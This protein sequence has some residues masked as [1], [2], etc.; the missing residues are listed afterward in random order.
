MTHNHR[1]Q[2]LHQEGQVSQQKA[3][4]SKSVRD[5]RLTDIIETG[6]FPTG[7]KRFSNMVALP[8]KLL[9]GGARLKFG[10]FR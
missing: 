6:N 7:A 9:L 3:N 8:E 2:G 1:V 5:T 4:L 10:E